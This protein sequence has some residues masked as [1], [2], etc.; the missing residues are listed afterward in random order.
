[1]LDQ[2]RKSSHGRRARKDDAVDPADNCLPQKRHR[3]RR[4]LNRAVGDDFVD[5][6]AARSKTLSR[7]RGRCVRSDPQHVFSMLRGQ[8]VSQSRT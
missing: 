2:A 7:H 8:L 6:Y 4:R 3:F 1:M 5:L